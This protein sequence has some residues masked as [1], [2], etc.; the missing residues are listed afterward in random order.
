MNTENEILLEH[1]DYACENGENQ[2]ICKKKIMCRSIV[3]TNLSG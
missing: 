2:I 1:S 3:V